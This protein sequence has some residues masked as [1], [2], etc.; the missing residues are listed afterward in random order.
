M[1]ALLHE[2]IHAAL[3]AAVLFPVFLCVVR[4]VRALAIP[5]WG[6]WQPWEWPYAIGVAAWPAILISIWVRV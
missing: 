4:I 2:L 5:R 1:N 6:S 3:P